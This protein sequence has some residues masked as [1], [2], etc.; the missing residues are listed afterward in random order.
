M[1]ANLYHNTVRVVLRAGLAIDMR[2]RR[3]R[4]Y[5]TSSCGVCGKVTA[6]NLRQ[7]CVPAADTALRLSSEFVVAL[8]GQLRQRQAVFTQTGG[9][10]AAALFD[11]HGNLLVLR[12]DVGRHNAMDKLVGWRLMQET[13]PGGE[14][15][16]MFSGRTSFELLQKA[17]R[18]GIPVVVS[19]G[20]PSS[21]A[22]ETA[23]MFN[24]TLVGFVRGNRFN[25]YTGFDRIVGG[26]QNSSLDGGGKG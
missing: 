15:V 5:T 26:V 13:M 16:V 17:A 8:P 9:L 14:S 23:R 21:L 10:H 1:Q 11:A 20:A 3:R 18:A 24:I 4:G 7:N 2:G 25:V 19:V 12:E 6:E 22:V